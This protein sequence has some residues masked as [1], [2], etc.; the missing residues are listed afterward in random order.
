MTHTYTDDRTR[1]LDALHH[2]D[3]GCARE[4]WHRIGRAAIAAG[5]TVDDLDDWSS[6]APNYTGTKDVKAAF[7][8]VKADGG[9]GPG[10]LFHLALEN[11][12][13]DTQSKATGKPRSRANGSGN[14]KT[15]PKAEKS[16]DRQKSDPAAIWAKCTP[17]TVEHGYIHRKRGLPGDLR[18]APHLTIAGQ[19]VAGF[20]AVP[21]RD[22]DGDLL[23]I[24]FI[25]EQGQ[26]LNMPGASLAGG[27]YIVEGPADRTGTCY[28]AEG[29]GTGW[30]AHQAGRH[31]AAV[32]F[33]KGNMSKIAADM[34]RRFPDLRIVLVPDRGGEHQ[35][36]EI[37][38]AIGMPAGHIELPQDKPANYDLNDLHLDEGLTA[39]AD[40]LEQIK[41][42]PEPPLWPSFDGSIE[43]FLH[44]TPPPL[45]WF[46][47]ERLL[48]GR[49]HL[50]TGIGGSS[51]TRLLFHLGI[52]A[53]IGHTPWGW[54]IDRT[55]SAALFLAEDTPDAIH[56]TIA[57]IA[58]H[59]PFTREERED[60]AKRLRVFPLAGHDTRLLAAAPG[61]GLLETEHAAG[62]IRRCK[63]IPDLRFI[64]LDPALALTEGDE[65]NA[66]HQRRL[67][68]FVDRLAIETGA[69]VVLVSHA[70]KA[71][72]SADE[73][74]SHTSR[75]SGALTDAVRGEFT[76]RTM[77]AAEA[78]QFG[79][80]DIEERK[81]HVQLVATKGNAL[82]PAAFVPLWLRRAAGGVLELAELA[83]PEGEAEVLSRRDTDALAI[84]REMTITGTVD[85]AE[86]KAECLI[87]GV[88]KSGTP[89][90]QKKAMQRIT[91]AL[92]VHGLI[93]RGLGRGV[94]IPVGGV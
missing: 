45:A 40:I 53:T 90:S 8:T 62:L 65:M 27:C 50:L 46:A 36:V 63:A 71:L 93:E 34:R 5:L 94:F 57:A 37:V 10:T 58:T 59:S 48:A 38:K 17:A 20:L 22:M 83:A 23:S 43:A 39:A 14:T 86:W 78:R 28:L 54:Q 13:T 44:T 49:A 11:G 6:T 12:W 32:T 84:L 74:G 80:A 4:E 68:E 76:L 9:T 55:G 1:A 79:I 21:V 92:L 75:G 16:P 72:Q 67:G 3:A 64:G 89:E 19:D 47:H 52:A 42:P 2:L 29:I 70:A 61:G 7:K 77:T 56:R 15:S 87:R 66:A 51:K 85:L 60:M 91:T 88:L 18:I 73:I 33:G 26:K 24:Q 31:P 25:P 69:C 35:A 82:P 81:G 41:G 30:S